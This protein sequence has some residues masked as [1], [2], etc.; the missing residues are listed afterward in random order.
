[1]DPSHERTSPPSAH[2][3]S[4]AAV[5]PKACADGNAAALDKALEAMAALLARASDQTAGRMA[6]TA[7]GNIVPKCLGAR[8]GTAAKGTE[9]LLLFVEA[10]CGEKVVVSSCWAAPVRGF[11]HSVTA[12]TKD[13]RKQ[14]LAAIMTPTCARAPR[15]IAPTRRPDPC[16]NPPPQAA[17]LEGLS[18]KVPKVVAGSLDALL[19]VVKAFGAR[20]LPAPVILKAL[21]PMFES[22]DAKARELTKLIVVRLGFG[23]LVAVF[24]VLGV[25]WGVH[26]WLQDSSGGR[27]LQMQQTGARSL[28]V[29][30]RPP[31]P[32][33][34]SWPAG[35]AP[36]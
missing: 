31:P 10:E 17:L 20:A 18:N 34:L 25:A 14:Q 24:E 12:E 6:N 11:G 15:P 19:Q 5:L 1:M 30:P 4:A 7:S 35:W 29:P 26:G 8:A 23:G 3:P 2:S 28:T 22:K 27:C 13:Q 32:P 16:P 21:P 9:C 36:S 33:R